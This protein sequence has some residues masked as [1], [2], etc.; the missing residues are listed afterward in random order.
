[1][2]INIG[3]GNVFY[4]AGVHETEA[5]VIWISSVLYMPRPIRKK[6]RLVDV[7]E[8]IGLGKGSKAKVEISLDGTFLLHPLF[9]V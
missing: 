2:P 9:K 7:L 5:G 3:I 8:G 4:E 6:V 1:M